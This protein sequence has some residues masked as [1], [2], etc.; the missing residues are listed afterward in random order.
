[1]QIR[2][3]ASASREQRD[4]IRMMTAMQRQV[5]MAYLM[6]Q[7][8]SPHQVRTQT[9]ACLGGWPWYQGVALK[10]CACVGVLLWVSFTSIAILW[11]QQRLLHLLSALSAS[12]GECCFACKL[13]L[14]HRLQFHRDQQRC[15]PPASFVCLLWL[16]SFGLRPCT[17]SPHKP[18][19]CTL[20]AKRLPQQS[21][22][23]QVPIPTAGELK[24]LDPAKQQAE[25]SHQAVL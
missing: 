22:V 12:C 14:A 1:M 3:Q 23:D 9:A 25:V 18:A 11:Q 7:F 24:K 17:R 15:P 21:Q 8:A 20:Q 16:S 13:E 10:S 5:P 19:L 2:E 6:N 4:M